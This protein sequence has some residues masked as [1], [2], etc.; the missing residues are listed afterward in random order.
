MKRLLIFL[1]FVVTFAHAGQWVFDNGT[2]RIRL[3]E[4]V[5]PVESIKAFIATHDPTVKIPQEALLR[6]QG[7]NVSACWVLL[8]EDNLVFIMDTD[9]DAAVVPLGYFSYDPAI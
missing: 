9:G 1:M 2:V 8:S 6:Y 7:R 5:C 3:T 4:I